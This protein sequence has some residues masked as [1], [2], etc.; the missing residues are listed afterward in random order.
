MHGV[1]AR[2][3]KA[4]TQHNLL[5]GIS[6]FRPF[7]DLFFGADHF[8]AV[9]FQ[10]AVANQIHR[11]IQPRL[12]TQRGEKRVRAFLANNLFDILPRDWFNIRAVS[13]IR[14][15]HD[16]GR[17]GIHQNDFVP[18]F[19]EGFAGLSSR[20][21]ELA[22]LA[23]YD[24]T[25]TN[26]QN[27]LDVVSTWHFAVVLPVAKYS[28]ADG[29]PPVAQKARKIWSSVT[30]IPRRSRTPHPMSQTKPWNAQNRPCCLSFGQTSCG[31]RFVMIFESWQSVEWV[32][33]KA[34]ISTIAELVFQGNRDYSAPGQTRAHDR[35]HMSREHPASIYAARRITSLSRKF[36]LCAATN[37]SPALCGYLSEC[38]CQFCLLT[39]HLGFGDRRLVLR[40]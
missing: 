13:R 40:T 25:G 26:D 33:E 32:R 22:S 38:P 31:R 7:D 12:S 10:H 28:D 14:I 39:C 21:I 3:I 18:V 23:N 19:A 34:R 30:A 17:I 9:F 24:R 16:R 8:D 27:L 15:R 4:D 1:A 11:G 29:D 2:N 6:F 37:F 36:F 5:E 20:I 35:K